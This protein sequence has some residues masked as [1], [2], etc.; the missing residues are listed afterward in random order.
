M[1]VW[2]ESDSRAHPAGLSIP[3][4]SEGHHLARGDSA[5]KEAIRPQRGLGEDST[6]RPAVRTDDLT[7]NDKKK[8]FPQRFDRQQCLP[9]FMMALSLP[10]IPSLMHLQSFPGE[11]NLWLSFKEFHKTVVDH[12]GPHIVR[13][14]NLMR[15]F[16][17]MGNCVCSS[18]SGKT[19]VSFR[20]I[21]PFIF[22]Y[23]K[24]K[25]PFC[26]KVA[27]EIEMCLLQTQDN[28]Q[29]K[30]ARKRR[31]E[32]LEGSVSPEGEANTCISFHATK[33]TFRM[34]QV[35]RDSLDWDD[36]QLAAHL[37]KTYENTLRSET[38][39]ACDFPLSHYC[40][41]CCHIA[42]KEQDFQLPSS[43]VPSSKPPSPHQPSPHQPSPQQP[44]PQQPSPHKPSP[45]KPSPQQPSLQQPSPQHPSPQHPSTQSTDDSDGMYECNI[46]WPQTSI[47]S[48][49]TSISSP[50]TNI[51]SPKT[52]ISSPKTNILSPQTGGGEVDLSQV[53]SESVLDEGQ[54]K[55]S[56]LAL[57]GVEIESLVSSAF[58]GLVPLSGETKKRIISGAVKKQVSLSCVKREGP[59]SDTGKQLLSPEVSRQ[60]SVA[61]MLHT[62]VKS[63][64]GG[65]MDLTKRKLL[66]AGVSGKRRHA[67]RRN[68]STQTPHQKQTT[69]TVL[70]SVCSEEKKTESTNVHSVFPL[71]S[72]VSKRR[73]RRGKV[74]SQRAE[75]GGAESSEW[76]GPLPYKCPQCDSGFTTF[77]LMMSHLRSHPYPNRWCPLCEKQL[78][79]AFSLS[80]HTCCNKVSITCT[81]CAA[82]RC[83][84][85]YD[86]HFRMHTGKKPYLCHLCGKEFSRRENFKVHFNIHTRLKLYS[87]SKCNKSFNSR[88]NLSRHKRTHSNEKRYVCEVCARRFKSASGLATHKM[89]HTGEKPY[90]CEECGAS[91]RH[92]QSLIIHKRVHTGEKPFE[93]EVCGRAFA[94]KNNCRAHRRTH[95]N[96]TGK[97]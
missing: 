92:S 9:G 72:A 49:K 48:P 86:A 1:S 66:K 95:K 94:S 37:I 70:G 13:R 28:V 54:Q 61:P 79:V 44:S 35:I 81:V 31:L 68:R 43:R 62:H 64:P 34:W 90:R 17:A 19:L 60:A 46:S 83:R 93:C 32:Q 88:G 30:L 58:P 12:P 76:K 91:Y 8:N 36:S 84:R 51:L 59:V 42:A 10:N 29:V 40:S 20:A 15:A 27:M 5:T 53:K 14:D 21:L 7:A 67:K 22:N 26:A 18:A 24:S 65:A 97:S 69:H 47:S 41:N 63:P 71:S 87:C 74:T 73:A 33:S 57:S 80:R 2:Q 96:E 89:T 39:A 3:Q 23:T 45:H 11:E 85:L 75:N 55:T 38:C 56:P 52:S 4:C 6:F 78:P 77:P 82:T 16:N 50:K 25:L